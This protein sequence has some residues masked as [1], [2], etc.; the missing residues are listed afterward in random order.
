MRFPTDKALNNLP[1]IASLCITLFL[2]L[3]LTVYSLNLH[4]VTTKVQTL[5]RGGLAVSAGTSLLLSLL[6]CI[7]TLGRVC[8]SICQI[9][10]VTVFVLVVFPNRTGEITGFETSKAVEGWLPYVKLFGLVAVGIFFAWRWPIHLR[11]AAHI[12]LLLAALVSGYISIFQRSSLGAGVSEEEGE[13]YHAAALGKEA[14]I[15]VIVPDTFTGYRMVEVFD[16]K[17]ELRKG[18]TGFTLYP[19]AV[20][21]A[22]NTPA[23]ISAILTGDLDLS[24]K[25]EN[26]LRRNTE[27]LSRSFLQDAVRSGFDAVYVSDQ[28][29]EPTEISTYRDHYFITTRDEEGN[30]RLGEYLNFWIASLNKNCAGTCA[31]AYQDS[32]EAYREKP[33]PRQRAELRSLPEHSFRTVSIFRVQT[34]D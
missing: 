11:S 23:G 30:G 5:L 19:R 26:G 25:I 4:C 7:P 9:A 18:F 14:N 12:V 17:P 21:S 28:T 33:V 6:S 34:G 32:H 31:Q 1:A 3:P 20:A 22:N 24:I 16:E 10:A 8:R 2:F 15:I 13:R 27:S 29:T